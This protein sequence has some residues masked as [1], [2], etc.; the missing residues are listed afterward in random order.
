MF[1]ITPPT[2]F[3]QIFCELFSILILLTKVSTM[4]RTLSRLIAK[5]QWV[6]LAPS[7]LQYSLKSLGCVYTTRKISWEY[8]VS[9]QNI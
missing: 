4:Q 1:I 8:S 9:S 7:C 6:R 5:H 3:L 2:A